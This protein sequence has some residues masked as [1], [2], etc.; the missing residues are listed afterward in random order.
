M[1]QPDKIP[2]RIF[3]C[4]LCLYQCEQ[5]WLLGRHLQLKHKQGKK[6]AKRVSEQCEYWLQPTQRYYRVDTLGRVDMVDTLEDEEI[7]D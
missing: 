7:V 4:P 5:R 6:E 2:V 3:S 1:T